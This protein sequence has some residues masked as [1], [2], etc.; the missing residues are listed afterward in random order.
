MRILREGHNALDWIEQFVATEGIDCDYSRVGRFCGAHSEKQFA[1]LK[2]RI[3]QTPEEFIRDSYLVDRSDQWDELGSHAYYGGMVST[4]H[5]SLDPAKYHQGLLQ[6]AIEAGVEVVDYCKVEKIHRANG[7]FRVMTSKGEVAADKVV[8]ATSG[9]TGNATPWHQR[10]IIPIGS[11]IIATEP[12]DGGLMKVLMPKNRVIVDTKK[13]VVYYRTSPDGQRILFG[14]RVSIGEIEAR[15]SVPK[16]H[17]LMC[18][19]F[20]QLQNVKVS[21]CWMGFVGYTFDGL[22]HIGEDEGLFYSMGYC[23][24]GISL[25]S[26]LGSKV[27][28]QVIGHRDGETALSEPNFQTR[29]L[30]SGKPW[31]LAPSVGYY[32]IRDRFS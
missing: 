16:M 19:I 9:Y 1:G 13:L 3:E 26:Y 12:I 22:P 14:G 18:E 4:R 11:Y 30:Y 25:S 8:V 5:A 6:L 17:R 27:G 24:S 10:R 28:Q 29:P 31:F 21:H 7:G 2:T 20:P 15:R 32:R 23:G